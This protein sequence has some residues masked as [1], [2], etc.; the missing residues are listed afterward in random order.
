MRSMA[1]VVNITLHAERDLAG[2]CQQV[3]AEYSHPAMDLLKRF[4]V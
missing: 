1:Y 4:F 2:L 3:N